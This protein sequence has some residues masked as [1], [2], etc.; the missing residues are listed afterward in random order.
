M[1]SEGPLLFPGAAG[2]RTLPRYPS[3]AF[4]TASA[5]SDA[6]T[7]DDSDDEII[8]WWVPPDDEPGVEVAFG[9]TGPAAG[10][11]IAGS[12][13]PGYLFVLHP[14][15][16]NEPMSAIVAIR[17]SPLRS[18]AFVVFEVLRI[19]ISS[20]GYLEQALCLA[21]VFS[22]ESGSAGSRA[23]KAYCA[24][25]NRPRPFGWGPIRTSR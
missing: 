9:A 11:L 3:S 5:S 15:I 17:R 10:A 23:P 20:D 25:G 2:P 21:N 6:E 7:P 13:L 1:L 4:K 19:V 8:A 24:A 18:L 22:A 16:A 14:N 12:P